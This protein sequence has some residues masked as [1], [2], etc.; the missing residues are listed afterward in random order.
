MSNEKT[1]PTIAPDMA[2][3]IA[4]IKAN[5]PDLHAAIVADAAHPTPVAVEVV[6]PPPAPVPALP[7]ATPPALRV[8]KRFP[9]GPGARRSAQAPVR[10]APGA[11]RPVPTFKERQ[12]KDAALRTRRPMQFD[13]EAVGK[14]RAARK[15][16]YAKYARKPFPV[17][18]PNRLRR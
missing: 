5:Y 2:D 4:H 18:K 13:P 3:Q 11:G 15:L 10:L 16:K 12:A 8:A 1:T 7:R 17:V 9:R 14:N 6:P